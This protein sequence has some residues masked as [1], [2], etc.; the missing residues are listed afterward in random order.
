MPANC[1]PQIK[2]SGGSHW[3]E[4]PQCDMKVMSENGPAVGSKAKVTAAVKW[5]VGETA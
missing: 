3:A 1:T 4:C 5:H 2:G